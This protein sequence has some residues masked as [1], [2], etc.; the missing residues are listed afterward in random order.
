V[1]NGVLL[2]PIASDVETWFAELDRFTDV[3]LFE[4]G[5]NQPPMPGDEDIFG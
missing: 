5:R 4:D 3:P 2:E 1:G